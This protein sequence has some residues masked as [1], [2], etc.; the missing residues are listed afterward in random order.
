MRKFINLALSNCFFFYFLIIIMYANYIY[1][2]FYLV[3]AKFTKA[4][5]SLIAFIYLKFFES[6]YLSL[7]LITNSN[8]IVCLNIKEIQLIYIKSKLLL[9]Y[10]QIKIPGITLERQLRFTTN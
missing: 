1:N 5:R 8:D 10:N 6:F 4:K 7:L 3:F 9:Y 2:K